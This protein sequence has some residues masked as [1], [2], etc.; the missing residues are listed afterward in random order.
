MSR[1]I[2]LVCGVFSSLL[3]VFTTVFVALQ[4]RGLQLRLSNGQ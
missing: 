3:Y 4:W 1:R 2:L